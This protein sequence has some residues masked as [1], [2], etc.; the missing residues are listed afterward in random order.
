MGSLECLMLKCGYVTKFTR[1][2][3]QLDYPWNIGIMG[4]KNEY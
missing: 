4:L 2:I 1:I 3:K